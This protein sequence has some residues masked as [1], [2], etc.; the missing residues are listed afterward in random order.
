MPPFEIR[1]AGYLGPGDRRYL[2]QLEERAARGPLAGKFTYHGELDRAE[3]IAFLQ[4]LDVFCV[5]AVYRES[6]GL[7]LLEAWAN[8]VPAVVPNH[9][10]YPELIADGGGGLLHRPADPADVADRLAEL[11]GDPARAA[12]LGRRGRRAVEDRYH[13]ETM[14]RETLE[15]YRRLVA[16]N[17]GA[18]VGA[19]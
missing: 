12:E 13:A 4:S 2:Q 15:L 3:K 11:L 8:G 6:K 10:T 18:P 7:P 14:A 17:Q 16:S 19:T 1:A 5:P 9:G